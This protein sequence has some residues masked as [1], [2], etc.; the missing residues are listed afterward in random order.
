[1]AVNGLLLFTRMTWEI[2][3]NASHN[4][5]IINSYWVFTKENGTEEKIADSKEIDLITFC[6]TASNQCVNNYIYLNTF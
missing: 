3:G 1:M 6:V 2:N 5:I 4:F